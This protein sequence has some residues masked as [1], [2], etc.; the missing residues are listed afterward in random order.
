M[1]TLGHIIERNE[2]LHPL[3]PALAFGEQ[4][5][6]HR[7]Y[8]QQARRL[9]S[10]LYLR[11]LRRQE[12]VA[13]LSMNG[14]EYAACYAAAEWAGYAIGTVNFRLA[15]AEIAWILKDTAPTILIFEAQYAEVVNGLRAQLESV[16]H[17][18]CIG[19][20][21]SWA[22]SFTDLLASGDDAGPPFRARP[23]DLLYLCYTS[24]TTGRPKGVMH[25]H[26]SC[27]AIA[28]VLCSELKFDAQ[29]RLLA[30][31]PMF[32]MGVRT[33]A[34]AAA[35]RGGSVVLQR[36]FDAE[37]VN[38]TFESER[39]TAVHLV[40]T[41]VQS[42]LDAPNFGQHDASTLKTLL[43]GAAPMPVT[44]LKRA[45][46]AFGPITWNGYGQTE[47][48][49]LTFLAPH[50]HA[51]D[52]DA[53]Q[54]QRL[55]SVGQ[56]HWQCELKIV[57]DAG[58]DLPS[59]AIGEVC[60][61][62]VTAMAGY[63]NNSR[64]TVDTV[65]DGWVRTGDMG[66]LDEEQYLFL[67]DRKKDMIISGGENVYSREVEEAL[68]AHDAIFEAAVIGVPDARWGEAVKAVVVLKAG[69]VLSDAEVIAHC[70]TQIAGYKCPKHVEFIDELP[71]LNTGKVNKVELR[72]RSAQAA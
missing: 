42:V 29:T 50:Q 55:A 14:P 17:Y 59:G 36:G 28:E 64:A 46:T 70:R 67:A 35:F 48:N 56:A 7:D 31:A 13:V 58:N 39:I 22:E 32:H 63:W 8:A 47:I 43:Y 26:D 20:A 3:R 44:L 65:R 12:R 27:V 19:E 72:A 37:A 49:G 60:A 54:M 25:R 62:S 18:V 16:R 6:T 38:R 45:V 33:L 52:G 5:W 61:R 10:A 11:G 21:P 34:L 23:D 53:A 4:R 57:D 66:W 41:M 2:R 71:R 9:A 30:V 1:T 40:P 51:L 68:L 15:P 69:A 24:G